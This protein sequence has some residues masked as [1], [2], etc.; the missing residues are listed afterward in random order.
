MSLC[1]VSLTR[2]GGTAMH[3]A[4]RI[5][6]SILAADRLHLYE[7]VEKMVSRIGDPEE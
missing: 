5:A 2:H 6:P 4:I 3:N 7:A 1:F